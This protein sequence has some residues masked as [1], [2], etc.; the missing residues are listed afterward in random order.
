MCHSRFT[1]LFILWQTLYA[2]KYVI[3]YLTHLISHWDAKTLLAIWALLRIKKNLFTYFALKIFCWNKLACLEF[4][5]FN[6]RLWTIVLVENLINNLILHLCFIQLKLFSV[7]TLV[8]LIYHSVQLK[9][10]F[11]MI[12]IILIKPKKK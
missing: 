5:Q 6:F 12:K 2:K 7:V 11:I 8:K 10:C 3:R 4:F 1:A 9:N